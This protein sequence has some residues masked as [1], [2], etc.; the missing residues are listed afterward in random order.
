M[1]TFSI[2]IYSLAGFFE[3]NGAVEPLTVNA[4]DPDFQIWQCAEEVIRMDGQ[5]GGKGQLV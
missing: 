5:V 3:E 4:G 2:N 1:G